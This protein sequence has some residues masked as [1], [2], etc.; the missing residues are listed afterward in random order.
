MSFKSWFWALLGAW[1]SWQGF[2]I[3]ILIQIWSL[4]FDTSLFQNLALYLNFNSAKNIHILWVLVLSFGGCWRFLT[5]VWHLDLDS[6]MVT[7]LWYNH[8]PNFCSHIICCLGWVQV[9]GCGECWIFL[10]GVWNLDLDSNMVTGLWYNH[11]SNHGSP[12]W[13]WGYKEHPCPLR[14][15]L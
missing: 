4:V 1:N 9:Q 2:S 10:T 14:P 15:H 8:D 6:N 13:L 3:L 11:E 7:G 5:G 12:S